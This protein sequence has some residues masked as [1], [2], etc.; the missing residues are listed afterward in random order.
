MGRNRVQDFKASPHAPVLPRTPNM[1]TLKKGHKNESRISADPDALRSRPLPRRFNVVP[2]FG[3]PILWLGS[4]NMKLRPPKRE[5]T[6]KFKS[7]GS[8]KT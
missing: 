4:Q 3:R 7:L 6:F 2:F 1:A 5:T 8:L